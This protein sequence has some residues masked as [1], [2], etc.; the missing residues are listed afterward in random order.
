MGAEFSRRCLVVL[1]VSTDLVSVYLCILRDNN[2]S[3]CGSTYQT[4]DQCQVYYLLLFF[5]IACI[6]SVYLYVAY[7]ICCV[8]VR[9]HVRRG[10]CVAIRGQHEGFRFLLPPCECQ[11][12]G[13]AT[14][15]LT[16]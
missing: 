14:S 13:L 12:S 16:H 8:F 7:F 6:D 15:P 5:I 11:A 2:G 10:I 4:L 1:E 3:G 9:V